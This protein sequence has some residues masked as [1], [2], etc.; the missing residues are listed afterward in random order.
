[1]TTEQSLPNSSTGSALPSEISPTINRRG[2]IAVVERSGRLLVIKRS[3]HVVA[4]GAYCFPGGGIEPGEAP[5]EA[6]EREMLEELGI[7][8]TAV[9]R[10]WESVTS[11]GTHLE[12][13]LVDLPADAALVAN[14]AEVELF[15]WLTP[16]ELAERSDLL[17]SNRQFLVELAAGRIV[18]SRLI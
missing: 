7:A 4:P 1:M 8:A 14:P 17:E 12:W 10:I 3:A 16:S 9:R 15:C 2:A 5:R 6:I 11:W 13:W 18:L